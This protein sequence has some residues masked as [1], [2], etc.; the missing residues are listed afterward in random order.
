[1]AVVESGTLTYAEFERCARE[2]S[3]VSSELGDGWRLE[4][5]GEEEEG[6]YLVKEETKTLVLGGSGHCEQ[7]D[8]LDSTTEEEYDPS[9]LPATP[10]ATTVHLQYHVLYSTSYLV[11]TLYLQAAKASGRLLSLPEL[12]SLLPP[13]L[14]GVAR[15]Q[16][17]LLTQAEHPRLGRPFFHLHPCHTASLMAMVPRGRGYLLSWLSSCGPL[18]GLRLPLAYAGTH[19]G[20][21]G[22]NDEPS[23]C[24][25]S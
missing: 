11:P 24:Q 12:W 8:D 21:R 9:T 2:L 19:P 5:E 17:S 18:V 13:C 3:R 16:W 4:G 1:M 14:V 20:G 25:D 10:P 7:P 22:Q 6:L 23:Q 15:P